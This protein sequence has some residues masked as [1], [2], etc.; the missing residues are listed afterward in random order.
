MSFW[1]QTPL[2]MTPSLL[3]LLHFSS[4]FI[5]LSGDF[6]AWEKTFS[7]RVKCPFFQW[8]EWGFLN[9]GE[10]KEAF[11][12]GFHFLAIRGGQENFNAFLSWPIRSPWMKKHQQ[13]D[14]KEKTKTKRGRREKSKSNKEIR[15]G[16]HHTR[17][18]M[19]HMR[20]TPIM[21]TQRS[22]QKVKKK[23]SWDCR[24]R[25]TTGRW[26]TKVSNVECDHQGGFSYQRP[27]DWLAVTIVPMCFIKHG[28]NPITFGG[29]LGCL[30]YQSHF[31]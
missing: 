8:D 5:F 3:F 27:H 17:T 28:P 12:E 21:E 25:A 23:T 20:N 18:Q 9:S 6:D 10:E 30:R 4:S 13:K 15:V 7:R 22:K 16:K 2:M 24:L 29:C 19:Q 14:R 1:Q 11:G 31:W 26:P